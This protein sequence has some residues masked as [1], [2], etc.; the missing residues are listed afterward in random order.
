VLDAMPASWLIALQA[1][2]VFG[3]AFLIGWVRGLVPGVFALPAR[4]GDLITGLLAVPVAISL[5]AGTLEA[6]EAAVA[7]NVFGLL[8]FAIAVSIALM[9]A[10]GPLQVIVPNI[11]NATTGIYP[12]VMVPAFAVPS[13]I[14]LHVLSL[15]Q[16][17]RCSR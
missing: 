14:L 5:A 16:L 4:I 10:P 12:N 17:S 9:I 13:S 1:Y 3:S 11:P 6:R 15:R 2:R 8:D 7:W